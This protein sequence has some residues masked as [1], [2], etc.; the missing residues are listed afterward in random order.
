M[1]EH[2]N[3]KSDPSVTAFDGEIDVHERH[4]ARAIE[5]ARRGLGW[6]SPNP[7]VGAVLVRD[8]QV[9]GEGFHS[10]AGAAHAEV[11]A[12]RSVVGDCRGARLYV[13]LEPCNH[14]GRTPPCTQAILDAGIAEVVIGAL[15]PNPNVSG[16]GTQALRAAGVIVQSGVLEDAATDLIRAFAFHAKHTRPYVIAKFGSSLDGRIATHTGAS[17]WITGSSSR[18]RVHELR[19]EVDA[20]LVGVD[21]VIADNPRLDARR[22]EPSAD[23]LPLIFDSTGRTPLSSHLVEQAAIRGTTVVATDAISGERQDALEAA[24]CTV[25][26]L[27]ADGSCRVDVASAL[28]RLGHEKVQSV[29]VE[30]GPTILGSFFDAGAVNEVWAFIAPIII[31][32]ADAPGAIGGIG[33]TTLESTNNFRRHSTVQL[34]E[35]ILVRLVACSQE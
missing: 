22:S 9:I 34:D 21:T 3:R 26:R 18:A 11:E 15:D 19:H 13:T 12:I 23:P 27:P 28:V 7:A 32:G 20:I 33:I 4:M 25:W 29:L 8:G 30:G 5:L 35:D 10:Q 16:G 14:H 1:G 6:C 24:G 2:S 31:G 17:K